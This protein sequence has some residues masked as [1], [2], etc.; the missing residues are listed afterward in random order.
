M[1]MKPAA[2]R[3]ASVDTLRGLTILTMIFVNDVGAAAPAWAKH[4]QPPDAN[5]MTVADVVFPAFLF[6]VGMSIPLA[7][8]KAKQT[9]VTL[10]KQPLHILSR[11]AA[12]LLMGSVQFNAAADTTLGKPW[13]GLLAFISILLAWSTIPRIGDS[14]RTVFQGLKGIGIVGLIVLLTIYRREPVPATVLLYGEAPQWV[15]LQT[16]WWGILGLI[17][18]AYLV[19]SLIYLAVGSRQAWLIG[20]MGL[21]IGIYFADHAGILD[22]LFGGYL[23]VG[24]VLGSQPSITLAG[25]LLGSIL[26]PNSELTQHRERIRWALTFAVGCVVVGAMTYPLAGINKIAATP[27]W[28]LWSSA[29]AIVVWVLLYVLMDVRGYT[30]WSKLIQPAGANPLI[31][32]LLHPIV[33]WSFSLGGFSSVLAYKASASSW[34]AML[35]SL[36]MAFVICGLTATIARLGLRVRL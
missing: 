2:E 31:A 10:T 15:W 18:W 26:L 3:V 33:F 13:W 21:L 36:G 12:L 4:I 14:K 27:T 23:D 7:F 22:A 30:G 20:A 11:T 34:I 25:C 28:G 29:I 6:I 8:E 9:G 32:Y 35:G 24:S 16:G 1:I 17:G 19:S 5:G